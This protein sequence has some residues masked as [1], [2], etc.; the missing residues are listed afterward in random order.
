MVFV[1]LF[2]QTKYLIHL[3]ISN[4]K[5]L[6]C[7][8]FMVLLKGHRHKKQP[9]DHMEAVR[10]RFCFKGKRPRENQLY[11]FILIVEIW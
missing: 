8:W 10:L 9:N 4:H 6:S 3:I 1:L 7:M 2:A 11:L 5:S